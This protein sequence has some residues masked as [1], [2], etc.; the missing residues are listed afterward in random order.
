MHQ[1]LKVRPI[2]PEK[3][4]KLTIVSM[5]RGFLNAEPPGPISSKMSVSSLRCTAL[6]TS[7]SWAHYDPYHFPYNA[8]YC[9][10]VF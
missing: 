5:M 6:G 8:N 1:F 10:N 9:Y 3:L 4:T 2:K 7:G